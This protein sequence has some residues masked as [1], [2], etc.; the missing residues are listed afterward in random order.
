MMHVDRSHFFQSVQRFLK[1]DSGRAIEGRALI[2]V[3]F[4]NNQRPEE[5]GVLKLDLSFCFDVVQ[6]QKATRRVRKRAMDRNESTSARGE[7][8]RR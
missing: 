6:R 5:I 4:V 3:C 7:S 8:K 2:T 1:K